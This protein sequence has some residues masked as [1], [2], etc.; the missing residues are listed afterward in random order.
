MPPAQSRGRAGGVNRLS[1]LNRLRC[2]VVEWTDPDLR[3]PPRMSFPDIRGV[4]DYSWFPPEAKEKEYLQVGRCSVF[5]TH[6]DALGHQLRD[7]PVATRPIR[8]SVINPTSGT[9]K[10]QAF[11][12][13]PLLASSGKSEEKGPES[14]ILCS[15]YRGTSLIRKSTPPQGHHRALL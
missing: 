6:I 14:R 7:I 4:R 8:R 1:P 11:K 15:L 13:L 10:K 2:T 3:L 9:H 5:F 12:I